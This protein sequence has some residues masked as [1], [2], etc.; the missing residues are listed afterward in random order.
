MLMVTKIFWSCP[1]KSA[2]KY[3]NMKL[4]YEVNF[5]VPY[6]YLLIIQI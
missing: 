3:K 5:R 4:T 1:P 2:E 6:L